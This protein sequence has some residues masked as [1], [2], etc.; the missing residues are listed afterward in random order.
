MADTQDNF[1]AHLNT[2][3][4]FS[5]LVLFAILFIVLILACMALGLVGNSGVF[6]LILGIGGSIALLIAFAVLG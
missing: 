2:Y 3:Q 6:A 4:S 1:P 5:K